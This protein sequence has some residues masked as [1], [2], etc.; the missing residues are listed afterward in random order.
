MMIRRNLIFEHA[1]PPESLAICPASFRRRL[2]VQKLQLLHRILPVIQRCASPRSRY[3]VIMF[4]K[5]PLLVARY[6]SYLLP[7]QANATHK[8]KQ[9]NMANKGMRNAVQ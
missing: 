5:F 2:S 3:F 6:C 7:K 8:E 9:T 4:G 1:R